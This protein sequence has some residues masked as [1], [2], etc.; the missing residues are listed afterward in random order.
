MGAPTDCP[1]CSRVLRLTT[2][3]MAALTVPACALSHDA[4]LSVCGAAPLDEPSLD[5]AQR[6]ALFGRLHHEVTHLADAVSAISEGRLSPTETWTITEDG[7]SMEVHGELLERDAETL[8]VA[9]VTF[10]HF[11][12]RHGGWGLS[13]LEGRVCV[14]ITVPSGGDRTIEVSGAIG[15]VEDGPLRGAPTAT[16]WYLEHAGEIIGR[17]GGTP[18]VAGSWVCPPRSQRSC[19]SLPRVLGA[20]TVRG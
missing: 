2:L 18:T 4:P 8:L 12:G 9:E 11:T 10:V 13:A 16:A 17:V 5:A 1:A 20:W 14:T 15:L 6:D 3:V 19:R 7:G